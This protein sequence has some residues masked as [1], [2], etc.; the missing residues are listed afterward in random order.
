MLHGVITV[1]VLQWGHELTFHMSSRY[2]GPRSVVAVRGPGQGKNELCRWTAGAEYMQHHLK[3]SL[4]LHFGRK[5]SGVW[6]NALFLPL[7]S[8]KRFDTVHF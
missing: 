1:P 5:V 7:H 2:I 6:D 8:R 4:V 3:P